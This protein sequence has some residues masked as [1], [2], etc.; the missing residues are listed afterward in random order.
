MSK[1]TERT[2]AKIAVAHFG[3]PDAPLRLILHRATAIYRVVHPATGQQYVLRLHHPSRHPIACVQSE[4]VYLKAICD[5]TDL[6]VPEPMPTTDGQRLSVVTHDGEQRFAALFKWVPGK[7]KHKLLA[8]KDATRL[9]IALGKLH[10]FTAGWQPPDN[11]VR[12]DFAAED[13]LDLEKITHKSTGL[14]C[15]LTQEDLRDVAQAIAFSQAIIGALPN[16]PQTYSLIHS[17]ANLSNFLHLPDQ[18]AI[19]DFEV[20]SYGYFLYD[21][22]RL[23]EEMEADAEKRQRLIEALLAGYGQHRALPTDVTAQVQAFSLLSVLD[24]LVWLCDQKSTAAQVFAHRD[25][26]LGRLQQLLRNSSIV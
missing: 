4:L 19:L 23:A 11:F 15:L 22:G 16:T 5:N 14:S 26:L 17:D 6:R 20:C 10:A 12:W 18:A 24:T 21:I 2:F 9:G 13:A 25:K 7:H 1:T 8:V 3:L